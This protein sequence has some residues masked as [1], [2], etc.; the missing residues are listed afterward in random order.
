VDVESQKEE[1]PA[2]EEQDCLTRS[3]RVQLRVVKYMFVS[4]NLASI[5]ISAYVLFIGNAAPNLWIPRNALIILG[6]IFGLILSVIAIRGGMKEELY[7]V[8]TY[9]VIVSIIYAL[10]LLNLML[11]NVY[12]A[13]ISTAYVAICFYYSLLIHLKPAKAVLPSDLMGEQMAIA[14]KVAVLRKSESRK[15]ENSSQSSSSRHMNASS[16]PA[17]RIPHQLSS[18]SAPLLMTQRQSPVIKQE[19]Q[20]NGQTLNDESGSGSPAAMNITSC[21]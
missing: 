15:R 20:D 14:A 12:S 9:S 16:R 13:T 17:A 10:C 3:K 21:I 1:S 19:N 6:L 8:L 11:T 4:M 5:A 7:L 2:Y 18:Q